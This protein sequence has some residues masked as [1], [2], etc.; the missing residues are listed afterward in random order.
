MDLSRGCLVAVSAA[1]V[2]T[3]L[4]PRTAPAV[5]VSPRLVQ[6]V[7]GTPQEAAI[8]ARMDQYRSAQEAGLID[9]APSQFALD[10]AKFPRDGIAHRN[11]LVVLAEFPADAYGGAVKHASPSTPAYY[12]R[13]L[14]SDDPTDGI[15]SMREFYRVNS[16]GRLD[17]SGRVIP[18]WLTMPHSAAYYINSQYGLYGQ[19]PRNSQKLAE[20]AMAAAYKEMENLSFFDDDGP[21]GIPGSGD[22]DG[23]ID[24]VLVIHPGIGA[25][26]DPSLNANLTSLWSHENGLAIYSNCPPAVAGPDC[27]PGLILGGVRGYLYVLAPEYNDYP[28]D[29]SCGTYFHEFGH[30][31]G[32]VDLYGAG[33]E[34][35]LGFFSLMGLGNYL[36]FDPACS[37]NCPVLGS[38]PGGF[39]AWSRQF[40]G[41]DTPTVATEARTYS[42]APLTR[43]GGSIKLWKNGEPGREYFL[44][45]NRLREGPDADLPGNGLVLYHVDDNQVDNTSGPAYYRVRLV[46]ADGQN[47]LEMDPSSGGNYGDAAD[48]FPGTGG[49]TS[50]TDVTTPSTRDYADQDTGLRLT[51]IA[52]TTTGPSPQGTFDLALSTA[53][54]LRLAGYVTDDG[55]GN[56]Y[57]DPGETVA[58]SITVRNVGTASGATNYTLSTPDAGITML[59][60]TDSEAGIAP[61]ATATLTGGFLFQVGTF[62]PTE[63]PHDVP[64][65]LAWND[66]SASGSI[67]FT[68]AVGMGSGLSSDFEAGLGSWISAGVAPTTLTDWHAS[69]SRAHGGAMSAKCGSTLPLGSGSNDA[70]TYDANMD[71]ALT[72][73]LFDLPSGQQLVF[74]SFMDAE[75]NG[76]TGAWDGGR[77]EIAGGDGDWKPLDPEGGY[78]YT[79]ESYY[80]NALRGSSAFSGSPNRW[81]RVVVDLSSY[82]GPTRIR[83]RFATDGANEPVDQFG[84]LIRRYE[85]WY[86]DDVSVEPR[87]DPGPAAH[88]V[89]LR[90]GPSPYRL[91]APSAGTIHIRFSARDG[92]PHSGIAP[93]VRVFD[94]KGRLVRTLT[95][96]PNGLLPTQF[97]ATWNVRDDDGRK[98]AAGIYFLQS[99]IQGQTESFRVV[100]L[101]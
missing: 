86:I 21:D 59:Q 65:T 31:L 27:L 84:G 44:V 34:G 36:P 26:V 78:P 23:Y 91:G 99:D 58:L 49:V 33:Y 71:A 16:H 67:D 10:L 56:G 22:D 93:K 40:L 81:Q 77:V 54:D 18:K 43:G 88:R 9:H 95:A 64:F 66:G 92:L 70:Q 2:V 7:R 13:L 29:N 1:L 20:D 60:A 57:P 97:E 17:I 39:D 42:L 73:P 48:P 38:R 87:V 75:A 14:F 11:V 72:S 101:K 47:E 85:G 82:S 55:G 61:Y 37:S 25:E 62:A 98:V 51:N 32:L 3:S 94:L 8:R 50:I 12:H 68:I 83:F 6:Q 100:V 30:T 5:A 53:P 79:L 80:D 46:A 76:G 4:T 35:G 45:E 90:A 41:F 63:L 24:A 19:Y 52:V 15:I 89:T 28:G 74:W 96:G 69:D